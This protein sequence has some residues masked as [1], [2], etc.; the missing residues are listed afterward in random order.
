M[1]P[2]FWCIIELLIAY[3]ALKIN[4]TQLSVNSFLQDATFEM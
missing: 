4:A 2:V 1:C 3:L